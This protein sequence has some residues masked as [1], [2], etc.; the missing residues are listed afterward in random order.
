MI[1]TS[2]YEFENA[3]QLYGVFLL[4]KSVVFVLLLF[5][6]QFDMNF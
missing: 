6:E 2:K 4:I 3:V 5:R 1:Q